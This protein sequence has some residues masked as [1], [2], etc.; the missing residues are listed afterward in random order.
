[1]GEPPV[2]TLLHL[3]KPINGPRQEITGK[4]FT[5]LREAS[6]IEEL[7]ATSRDSL[8]SPTTEKAL[9]RQIALRFLGDTT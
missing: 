7:R 4:A 5:V 8:R 2:K 9:R 1:M 3:S 6:I